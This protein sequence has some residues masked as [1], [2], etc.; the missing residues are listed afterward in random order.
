[1]RNYM[2]WLWSNIGLALLILT[3]AV[4]AWRRKN[5]ISNRY[6]CWLFEN[7][8]TIFSKKKT[9]SNLQLTSFRSLRKCDSICSQFVSGKLMPRKRYGLLLF[10]KKKNKSFSLI[11]EKIYLYRSKNNQLNDLVFGQK[12]NVFSYEPFQVFPSFLRF[13]STPTCSNYIAFQFGESSLQTKKRNLQIDHKSSYGHNTHRHAHIHAL[14]LLTLT[15]MGTMTHMFHMTNVKRLKWLRIPTVAFAYVC[16][17]VFGFKIEETDKERQKNNNCWNMCKSIVISYFY[18]R[19]FI[20]QWHI[21]I[22]LFFSSMILF[23]LLSFSLFSS[24]VNDRCICGRFF[25]SFRLCLVLCALLCFRSHNFFLSSLELVPFLLIKSVMLHFVVSN[26]G[27]FAA[28][29]N[30]LFAY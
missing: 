10:Q 4:L 2:I 19:S 28:F 8:R 12:N 6:L 29:L 27:N 15:G 20:S 14:L 17:K 24:F 23:W 5:A 26:N 3:V 25:L 11:S 7:D 16:E 21:G 1:M 22:G 30:S 13:V 18:G 9:C